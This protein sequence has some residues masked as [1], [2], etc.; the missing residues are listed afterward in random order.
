MKLE[1]MLEILE[2]NPSEVP[3]TNLHGVNLYSDFGPRPLARL[4]PN[5][6]GYTL[7]FGSEK[8]SW[9][10]YYSSSLDALPSGG[11]RVRPI[12]KM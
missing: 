5:G 1:S 2:L 8:F 3:P 9:N 11:I 4:L 12:Y 7:R 10:D 6:K